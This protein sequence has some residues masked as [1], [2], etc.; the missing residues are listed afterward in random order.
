MKGLLNKVFC[1]IFGHDAGPF[2]KEGENGCRV[3]CTRCGT[4]MWFRNTRLVGLED[5]R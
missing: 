2:L 4:K 1:A 5:E 3:Y